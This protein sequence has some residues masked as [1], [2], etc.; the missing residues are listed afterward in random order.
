MSSYPIITQSDSAPYSGPDG[1]GFTFQTKVIDGPPPRTRVM[2]GVN[3]PLQAALS[4]VTAP[5]VRRYYGMNKP[6]DGARAV[7]DVAADAKAQVHT[8]L[9]VGPGNPAAPYNSEAMESFRVALE[10]DNAIVIPWHEPD[11]TAPS[12]AV[13]RS[14]YENVALQFPAATLCPVLM[15]ITYSNGKASDWL[16]GLSRAAFY[17]ADPYIHDGQTVTGQYDPARKFAEA[18]NKQ[19]IIAETGVLKGADQAGTLNAIRLYC[20][21][22][23]SIFAVCYWSNIGKPPYDWTLQPA[24]LATF[25]ALLKSPPFSADN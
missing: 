16:N 5:M 13:W 9:S 20:Q 2:L 15:G 25:V 14:F 21:A 19:L 6:G 11:N 24:G 18:A 1:V 17:G 23:L 10:A 4:G 3:V 8:L 7:K 22:Y 12:P